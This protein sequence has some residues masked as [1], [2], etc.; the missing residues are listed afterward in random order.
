[1]QDASILPL[2][3]APG[4]CHVPECSGVYVVP[5]DPCR[6]MAPGRIPT[7]VLRPD[8]GIPCLTILSAIDLIGRR[9]A[10]PRRASARPV[11]SISSAAP[12]RRAVHTPRLRS[13]VLAVAPTRRSA[14]PACPLRA[15]RRHGNTTWLQRL[16]S[17]RARSG[18]SHATLSGQTASARRV[19]SP[20]GHHVTTSTARHPRRRPLSVAAI[21]CSPRGMLFDGQ[22]V[23]RSRCVGSSLPE[24]TMRPMRRR[25]SWYHCSTS[26]PSWSHRP[27]RLAALF[28]V[29]WR[30]RVA[31]RFRRLR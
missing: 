20:S 2:P 9:L 14:L 8:A 5:L 21:E 24:A 23:Y 10:F 18:C 27:R 11:A 17:D 25:S 16:S 12:A 4:P 6:A 1:M 26:S 13:S 29:A 19:R 15:H 30:A 22:P 7:P 28:R 31:M 3:L